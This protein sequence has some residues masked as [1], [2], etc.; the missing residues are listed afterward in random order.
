MLET[1]IV[2]ATVCICVAIAG[3]AL[4]YCFDGLYKSR[5]DIAT[6]QMNFEMERMKLDFGVNNG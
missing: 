2:C 1:I 3:V 6:M 5:K 4:G